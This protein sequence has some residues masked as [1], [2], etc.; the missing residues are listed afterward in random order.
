[1]GKDEEDFISRAIIDL[2]KF[3]Y[4]TDDEIPEPKWHNLYFKT[5]AAVSGEILLSFAVVPDDYNFKKHINNQSATFFDR[6][7]ETLVE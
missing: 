7:V 5:G 4:S 2:H 1:M 6:S 3:E